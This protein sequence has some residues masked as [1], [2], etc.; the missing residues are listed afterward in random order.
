[1]HERDDDGPAVEITFRG[2]RVSDETVR[3]VMRCVARMH[4]RRGQADEHTWVLVERH[5]PGEI[6]VVVAVMPTIGAEPVI[7]LGT[8]A[9]PLLAVSN[10][11]ARL[12]H[13]RADE[14]PQPVLH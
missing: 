5:R 11:F 3:Y 2:V 13:R 6:Q 10:A 8:E 1:M 12:E 7:E 14:A 4:R 9:D